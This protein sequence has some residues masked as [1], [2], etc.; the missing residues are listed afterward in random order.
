MSLVVKEG[1]DF[2]AVE[3][4]AENGDCMTIVYCDHNSSQAGCV[5]KLLDYLGKSNEIEEVA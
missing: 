2:W 5:S 3:K 4:V 1:Y